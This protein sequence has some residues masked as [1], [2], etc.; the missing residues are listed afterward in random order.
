MQIV[1]QFDNV[2]AAQLGKRFAAEN[3]LD[4]AL[5]YPLDLLP[6]A[7][8]RLAIGLD[9]PIKQVGDCLRPGRSFAFLLA[10]ALF[11]GR[12]IDPGCRSCGNGECPPPCVRKGSRRINT[13]GFAFSL[14]AFGAIPDRERSTAIRR[15]TKL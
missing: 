15:H 1:E 4:M 12:Q 11:I 2:C 10:L 13:V 5:E 7:L 9:I 6:I 8:V 3:R 14:A